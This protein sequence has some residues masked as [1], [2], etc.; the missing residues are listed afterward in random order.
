[1]PLFSQS[2]TSSG[3]RSR[4]RPRRRTTTAVAVGLAPST[5]SWLEHA[6]GRVH[7]G[8]GREM[9]D[10]AR[11]RRPARRRSARGARSTCRPGPAARPRSGRAPPSDEHVGPSAPSTLTRCPFATC[12]SRAR[13]GPP[14]TRRRR[15]PRRSARAHRAP[16]S[17]ECAISTSDDVD[18]EP[19]RERRH[20]GEHA[21][22]VGHRHAQ[23]DEL[24]RHRDRPPGGSAAP[25]GPGR[26]ARASASRSPA[27]TMSR[28]CCSPARYASSAPS[29]ASRFDVRMSSQIVGWLAAIRVMSR[30]PPAASRSSA[31]CSRLVRRGDVHQRRR[32]ELRHVAHERDEHV[33][34]VGRHRDDLGLQIAQQTAAARCTRLP[35]SSVVGVST[36]AAP[37]NRS[38]RAPSMPSCSEPAIGWPPTKRAARPAAPAR[39]LGDDRALHRTDV[40]D[41][42]HARVE[43]RR[44]PR[45]R[46]RRPA[47]RRTRRRR[48]APRAARSRRPTPTA[49]SSC[50]RAS[51]SRVAVEADDVVPE[52]AR[53]RARSSRRSGPSR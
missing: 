17:I 49:P 44:P 32:R 40:G 33:V 27:A 50:A 28:A 25:R 20:L 16:P 52:R 23:L 51:R 31:R 53:A 30:K 46:S 5:P 41:E 4:R 11:A 1:M 26:A 29:T 37:T 19:A 2:S 9:R 47:P 43:Q 42:R 7:V 48:R 13:A 21:G 36:H 14:R 15:R 10:R 39:D 24:R 8:A 3:S 45:P 38:A 18:A 6:R 22:P 12:G 34:I 35:R